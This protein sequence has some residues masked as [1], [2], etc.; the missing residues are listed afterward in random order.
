[1]NTEIFSI[2][3]KNGYNLLFTLFKHDSNTPKNAT[4]LIAP[5]MAVLQRYYRS[6]A[7]YLSLKGYN[8][9]TFDYLGIGESKI[10]IYDNTITYEDWAKYDITF[11]IDWIEQNLQ[12]KIYYIAHSAGGQLLGLSPSAKKLNK[13]FIISSGIGYWKNWPFPK[14]YFYFISW[15][16][17]YPAILKLYG[18]SP[19]FAMGEIVPKSIMKQWLIWARKKKFVLGDSSIQTYYEEISTD[20][21]FI[22]FS[23]DTYSPYKN[24]KELA[25]FYSSAKLNFHLLKPKEFKLKSIGHFGFFRSKYKDTLWPLLNL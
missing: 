10:D 13:I 23:D 5:A 14:K 15:Y 19:K 18:Y 20:I 21:E 12:T 17:F 22:A 2:K 7:E 1:M 24:S 6:F 9:I 4:I 11:L 3:S 16:L 25:S 8:V